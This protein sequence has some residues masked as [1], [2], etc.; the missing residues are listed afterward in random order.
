MNPL[1]PL[2]VFGVPFI[3]G[4]ILALSG[5][6]GGVAPEDNTSI[7]SGDT[8]PPIIK[9]IGQTIIYQ[10]SGLEYSDPGATAYDNTDGDITAQIKVDN[11]VNTRVIGTY[12]VRYTVADQ[13]GNVATPAIRTVKVVQSIIKQT[14]QTKSYNAAGDLNESLMDDG[15]YQKGVTPDYTRDDTTQI[16]LDRITGLE[17]QDDVL[18]T[19]TFD[20][21]KTYCENLTLGGYDDWRMPSIRELMNITRHTDDPVPDAFQ[22][23]NDDINYWSGTSSESDTTKAWGVSMTSGTDSIMPK[24]QDKY[25]RCVRG[26][27]PTPKSLQRDDVRQVVVD[28]NTG[29]EWQDDSIQVK[30]WEE[31]LAYCENLVLGGNR[32][33][34]PNYNELYMLLDRTQSDAESNVFKKKANDFMWTSTTYAG[35]KTDA[36]IIKSNHG[37]DKWFS[38]NSLWKIRCVSDTARQTTHET[39]ST[40]LAFPELHVRPQNGVSRR[41]TVDISRIDTASIGSVRIYRSTQNDP[42]TKALVHQ[43]NSNLPQNLTWNDDGLEGCHTYYY[44]IE[45]CG[46]SGSS[47]RLS[48]QAVSNYPV[49]SPPDGI[50]VSNLLIRSLYVHWINNTDGCTVRYHVFGS[51]DSNYTY[52]QIPDQNDI[53]DGTT[54]ATILNVTPDRYFFYRIQS[55]DDRGYTSELSCTAK[56]SNDTLRASANGYSHD[57][58]AAVGYVYNDRPQFQT[59]TMNQDNKIDFYWEDVP[60]E[61][62]ADGSIR[63]YAN[64]Y[65]VTYNGTA[66]NVSNP[67]VSNGRQYQQFTITGAVHN[68]TA[69]IQ[70]QTHYLYDIDGDGALEHVY[71][72]PISI[73]GKTRPASNTLHPLGETYFVI[74][75]TYYPNKI[76][77]GWGSVDRATYYKLYRKNYNGSC[78]NGAYSY[79]K[80]VM[81]TRY[82]DNVGSWQEYCYKVQA[83]NNAECGHISTAYDYGNTTGI[84]Q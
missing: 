53:V 49:P 10:Q 7:T 15:H 20:T 82:D 54:G 40:P 77:V 22:A 4:L 34:L 52:S 81:S 47:C 46:Q 41:L 13:A 73:T 71:S 68:Q 31:A 6:G 66:Y 25:V 75:T 3:A 28:P 83:C 32:W 11:P 36:M 51:G 29:L 76:F 39:N 17:W 72:D 35:K 1:I 61:K 50:E 67:F 37:D 24:T 45:T 26:E 65:K 27:T 58:L 8:T 14:G 70:V 43:V 5:C 78:S 2:R 21:A 62:N 23:R 16:V 44:W 42:A 19:H 56:E 60:I 69:T 64:A 74:A 12:T 30:K 57:C 84:S 18:E 38:K 9:L 48:S 79:Y 63:T 33:R 80:T 59:A 55:E